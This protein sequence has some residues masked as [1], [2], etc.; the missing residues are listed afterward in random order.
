MAGMAA[1]LPD[2]KWLPITCVDNVCI[3]EYGNRV[4]NLICLLLDIIYGPMF[5]EY[6]SVIANADIQ[7]NREQ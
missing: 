6:S 2:G 7:S 5:L 1:I 4:V 3:S